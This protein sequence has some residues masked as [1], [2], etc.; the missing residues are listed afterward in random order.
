MTTP[1]RP[2]PTCGTP[3]EQHG[4]A[5]ICPKQR[6]EEKVVSAEV[7]ASVKATAEARVKSAPF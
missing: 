5:W 6:D 1:T 3:M 4:R 2:C 7:R